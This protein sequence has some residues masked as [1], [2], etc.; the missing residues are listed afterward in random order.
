[1][2]VPHQRTEPLKMALRLHKTAL[3][4]RSTRG[5]DMAKKTKATHGKKL[6]STKI[7]GVKPLMKMAQ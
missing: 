5:A 7:K 6:R 1:M 3:A 4:V 2:A